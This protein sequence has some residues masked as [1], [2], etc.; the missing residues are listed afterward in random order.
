MGVNS[1]RGRV[2]PHQ[3]FLLRAWNRVRVQRHA[4]GRLAGGR[5]VP[6]KV[7]ADNSSMVMF[8]WGK[9]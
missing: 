4:V 1:V 2:K 5:T 6:V 8:E 3:H 9:V 7:A